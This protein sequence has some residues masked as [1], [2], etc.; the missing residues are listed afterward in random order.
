MK[1]YDLPRN[2][3]FLTIFHSGLTEFKWGRT[4]S[5]RY[6]M[7][8]EIIFQ[9]G[10]GNDECGLEVLSKIE[11]A[12]IRLTNRCYVCSTFIPKIT[13]DSATLNLSHTAQDDDGE[14]IQLEIFALNSQSYTW[15]QEG[16]LYT[17]VENIKVE[18]TTFQIE[19]KSFR[20]IA[21]FPDGENLVCRLRDILMRLS[22]R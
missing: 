15:Y 5:E 9:I 14:V 12:F 13:T 3:M 10:A 6:E 2:A 21:H 22:N 7:Y 20:N 4:I 16:R 17:F 18:K 1:I 8:R 19:F 11:D